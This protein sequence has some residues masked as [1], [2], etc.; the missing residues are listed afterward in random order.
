[1][2]V[3]YKLACH[4]KAEQGERCKGLTRWQ[5]QCACDVH[6]QLKTGTRTGVAW[7]SAQNCWQGLIQIQRKLANSSLHNNAEAAAS[8]LVLRHLTFAI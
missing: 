4:N 2:S 1:M 5:Q 8:A 7:F 6:V 3:L